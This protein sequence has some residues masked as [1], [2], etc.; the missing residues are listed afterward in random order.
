V[1]LTQHGRC[2]VAFHLI[3][4]STRTL[5]DDL[6]TRGRIRGDPALER[7]RRRGYAD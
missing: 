5:N 3:G 2:A 7:W 6:M 4:G 1:I